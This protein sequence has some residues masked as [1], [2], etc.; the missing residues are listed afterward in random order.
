MNRIDQIPSETL[1][2]LHILLTDKRK[3]LGISEVLPEH[4]FR[5]SIHLILHIAQHSIRRN[6]LV[7]LV[8]ELVFP[9]K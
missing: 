8:T 3:A 2:I 6:H 9:P 4:I 7:L 1:N 5:R